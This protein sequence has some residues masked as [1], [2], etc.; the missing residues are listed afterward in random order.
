M[1]SDKYYFSSSVR[2]DKI[3]YQLNHINNHKDSSINYSIN[4]LISSI[5]Q[6]T[7]FDFIEFY[8]DKY[9]DILSEYQSIVENYI[10]SNN[11]TIKKKIQ[12]LSY[13]LLLI[14]L[15]YSECEIKVLYSFDELKQKI[16]TK[17]PS[18][19][20]NVTD[21]FHC[22]QLNEY[23]DKKITNQS[24][25]YILFKS[26][27][28]FGDRIQCLLYVIQY[29]L[30]TNRILVIDWTDDTW[31]TDEKYDFDTYFFIK[32]V[33]IMKY[34]DFKEF[35]KTKKHNLSIYPTYWNENIFSHKINN[36][37]EVCLPNKNTIL[38]D[39]IIN[40]SGDFK[41][42]ILIY[43]GS[44]YRYINYRLFKNHFRINSYI[45]DIIFQTDFYQTILSKKEKYCVI[46]LR[47]GD[48][49]VHKSN[50]KHLLW[51]NNSI[52]EDE[53]VDQLL[54]QL[55]DS[56]QNIL[57]L[58]D[59]I[60]LLDKCYSKLKDKPYTIYMTNNTKQNENKGLHKIKDIYK[61]QI[62]QEMLTDFYFMI[63]ADKIISDNYSAFSNICKSITY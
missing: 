46:H 6:D 23:F 62:N 61:S 53:Y 22:Y 13:Q 26:F 38:N 25:K 59:T 51:N 32:D 39:I 8:H 33:P 60:S 29:C 15:T 52:H 34:K 58:S 28:G 30:H 3:I 2:T 4:S 7:L 47:G 56:Y 63:Q 14:L 21:I 57:L 16:K 50:K 54:Q 41:E 42:D 19:G 40:K 17:L 43:V 18:N 24:P 48:K 44:Q 35:Y 10:K 11:I 37:N 27:N 5:D 1:D 36:L 49:M 9:N 12:D 20:F 55:D 45:L 31:S